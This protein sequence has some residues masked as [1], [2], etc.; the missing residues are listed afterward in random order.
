MG[1]THAGTYTDSIMFVACYYTIAAVAFLGNLA[2]MASVK[3]V[4]TAV[5]DWYFPSRGQALRLSRCCECVCVCVC[6]CDW[7]NVYVSVS[8]WVLDAQFYSTGTIKRKL[9]VCDSL[10]RAWQVSI[11]FEYRFGVVSALLFVPL[12]CLLYA[13]V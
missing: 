3:A 4:T 13:C 8:S 9:C 7:S 2:A 11:N 1:F 12:S 6:V 10:P 5:E